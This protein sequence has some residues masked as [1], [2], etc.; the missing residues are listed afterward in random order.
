M[1]MC[2]AKDHLHVL[3]VA[4]FQLLL[5][6]ATSMLVLAIPI[7]ITR[8]SLE[9]NVGKPVCCFFLINYQKNYSEGEQTFSIVGSLRNIAVLNIMSLMIYIAG[10]SALCV[11]RTVGPI[12][13]CMK[14][15]VCHVRYVHVS[16]GSIYP[17]RRKGSNPGRGHDRHG[18]DAGRERRTKCKSSVSL[19]I[20]QL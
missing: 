12:R 16:I 6:V 19:H 7:D 18:V 10:L 17:R 2:F 9:L 5:Q 3:W 14:N 1:S 15:I 8:Q 20:Y 4:F 11:Q 13:C